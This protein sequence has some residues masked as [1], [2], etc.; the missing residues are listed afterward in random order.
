MK[1]FIHTNHG[2]IETPA[3]FPDATY[4]TIKALTWDD[5][6]KTGTN[7]IVTTTLHLE[8]KRGSEYIDQMGGVHGFFGLNKPILSDSGGYQVFSLIYRRPGNKNAI[9]DAGCSFIDPENGKYHFLSPEISQIIQFNLGTDIVTVLDVPVQHDAPTSQLKQAIKRN[10][11]W[12]KR[13]KDKFL[14]LHHL[15]EQDFNNPKIKR[16]LI[17]AVIQGGNNKDL[18][19]QSAEELLSIGFDLYNFGGPPIHKEKDWRSNAPR[20]FHHEMLE[21]VSNLIPDDKIKYAMGVGSPDDMIFSTKVGWD[22]FD[23]VLPTRNGRHGYL[24]VSKGHGN[25]DFNNYSVLNIKGKRYKFSN[26]PVD[27]NCKCECCST[28]TRA[29]LRH[30]IKINDAV[31]W[32]LASIHNL[33]YFQKTIDSIKLQYEN[34]S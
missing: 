34:D 25:K 1:K 9:T 7:Q 27:P 26:K 13:S 11:Q 28:V 2:K 17:G 5:L 24:Y 15:T 6:E 21:Y 4:G 23:T 33:T 3:F 10:T 20:G 8:Q 14:E 19:K 18:R 12:A 29:Y 31:G 22:I 32:R 30:L 16:P